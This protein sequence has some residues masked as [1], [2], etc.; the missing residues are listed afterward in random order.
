MTD[1]RENAPVERATTAPD[2]DDRSEGA[3]GVEP[4]DEAPEIRPSVVAFANPTA[5]KG[6]VGRRL[7]ALR[8][9]LVETWPGLEIFITHAA[10]DAARILHELPLPKGSLVLAIGGDGTVHEIGVALHEREG[11]A[12]GVVP[13]GS[14]NDVARQLGMPRDPLAS[15][16]AIKD[17][18]ALPWDLGMVGPFPFLNSVGFAL[19]AETCY[20]SH[21]TG[22]LTGIA[23]YGLATAR[24]WWT[25]E[26][27]TLG[28][29]GM[30]RSGTRVCT[31]IEVGI[32]DRSGGGFF[33]TREA[34]V[35]DGLLDVCLVEAL[36]RWQI[37]LLAPRARKGEHLD[38]PSVT[39]E[40]RGNFRIQLSQDTRIHVDGEIRELPKGEHSVRV[41]S[42]ALQLVVGPDHP[43]AIIARTPEPEGVTTV[44]TAGDEE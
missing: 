12:M 7:V 42:R 44:V 38:H 4:V 16:S 3:E 29:D 6:A 40:Q 17:G 25:H 11:V 41:R 39:Y 27:L 34:I 15:L 23:R 28:I 20:W 10:G 14:G 2:S 36:P 22:P 26:P 1:P 13:F 19:S 37:P 33:L 31:L 9:R 21:R 24:A 5:G 43:R 8:E 32:G 30:E 35:D 18:V